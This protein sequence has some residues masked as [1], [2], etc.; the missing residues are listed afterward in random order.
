MKYS[1]KNLNYQELGFKH[2]IKCNNKLVIKTKH[3]S[4]RAL[5]SPHADKRGLDQFDYVI[6]NN[7]DK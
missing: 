6:Y 2:Q 5:R 3:R 4:M 7:F 1:H